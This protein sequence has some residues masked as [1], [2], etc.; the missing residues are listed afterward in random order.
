MKTALRNVAWLAALAENAL[1]DV[2]DAGDEARFAPGK[3]LMGELEVG[4]DLFILL[5]GTARDTVAAGQA[6][7]IEIGSL[8][9]GDTCGEL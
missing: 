6:T 3:A 1:D 8:G 2:L 4:D 5:D 7:P 9:P